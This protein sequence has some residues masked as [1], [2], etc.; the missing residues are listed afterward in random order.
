MSK[1]IFNDC[2][3]NAIWIGDKVSVIDNRNLNGTVIKLFISTIARKQMINIRYK[4]GSTDV[5][6]C[7]Q[8]EVIKKNPKGLK[9]NQND[10]LSIYVAGPSARL[11]DMKNIIK[12][13]K[14]RGHSIT[15]DWPKQFEKEKEFLNKN[16]FISNNCKEKI[17]IPETVG[18]IQGVKYA[19]VL[20]AVF[21]TDVK[22]IGV[23]Y[24][25][26]AAMIS[27]TPIIPVSIGG[28]H[29]VIDSFF[30]NHPFVV[31][32]VFGGVYRAL[33]FIDRFDIKKFRQDAAKM[34][35]EQDEV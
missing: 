4:D 3:N 30:F 23:M 22:S 26:G 33:D 9:L 28:R 18:C 12:T 14:R 21:F 5:Y 8:V 25:F 2:K 27:Q 24:E 29:K 35:G 19:D 32:E 6:D 34:E 16:R 10:N 11:H 15:Y 31:K 1:N 13:V 20:I 17:L 7:D